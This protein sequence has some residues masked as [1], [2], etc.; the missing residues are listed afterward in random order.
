MTPD[1]WSHTTTPLSREGVE[2][3]LRAAGASDAFGR[4]PADLRAFASEPE[5][6]RRLF[7]ATDSYVDA[8]ERLEPVQGGHLLHL[9]ADSQWVFHWLA[10]I[11][12]DG[13]TGV[14]CS[15]AALGYSDDAEADGAP[16]GGRD[17]P[18]F[19]SPAPFFRKQRPR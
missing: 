6:R 2:R 9:V 4:L 3:P 5:L 1:D 14:V 17:E 8:G 18:V 7:S 10:V 19:P 12:D 11:G 15:A 16:G 13:S